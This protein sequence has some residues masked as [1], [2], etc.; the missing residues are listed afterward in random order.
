[1]RVPAAIGRMLLVAPAYFALLMALGATGFYAPVYRAIGNTCFG[2]FGSGRIA[3]FA[4]I[5][6][7]AGIADTGL[8]VGSNSKGVPG[9]GS[10]MKISSLREGYAPIAM[11]AA[12]IFATP[13]SWAARRRMLWIGLLA[14]HGFIVLR[15]LVSVVY[16]FSVVGLDGRLL[17]ET[18]PVVKSLI[19]RANQIIA[20]ELNGSYLVPFL[21]WLALALRLEQFR[22]HF[23]PETRSEGAAARR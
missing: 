7:P 2:S 15:M 4:P 21:V 8:S 3:R 12:L 1:M 13:V 18:G 17:L 10:T 9:Y 22:A 14:I 16:G 11:I 23:R 6:D 5:V 20:G 19:W